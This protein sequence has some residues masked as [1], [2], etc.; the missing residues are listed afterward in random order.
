MVSNWDTYSRQGLDLASSAAS[1]GFSAAKFGTRL[2]FAVTRGIAST[3]VG[4]TTS[5]VDHTLFGG[6]TVTRPVVSGAVSTVLSLAEQITLAPI[7]L[8]EYITST[9]FLAAHSSIN[10]LSLIFPGSSEASFSLASFITLVKRE[11]SEP[12][13]SDRLPQ[14]QFGITQVARAIVAWVALQ[15]VTQEWQEKRWLKHL[16][17]INVNEPPKNHQ[18]SLRTRRGSRIRVTSDVIFSGTRSHIITADI[19]VAPSRAQTIFSSKHQMARPAKIPPVMAATPRQMSIAELKTT[20]R[21]LSKMVLAGYGGA[22]LLFFGVPLTS[23]AAGRLPSG[24]PQVKAEEA[25]LANAVIA[26]EAE[27]AG[28]GSEPS[29]APAQVEYSWWDVLLGRHDHEI[30]EKFAQA[31]NDKMKAD[32]KIGREHLMPRFW[33]LTD[34][35]RGQVVLVLRGTMSLNEIAVDLTC[36]SEEFEPATTEVDEE[37]ES[38]VPGRFL[39]PRVPLSRRSSNATLP[40][41]RY[42]VHSGMLRMARA[43]GEVGKPVQLAVHEALYKNPGYE[44]VLCGHSLG[45]GVAALLGLMWADPRTCLTVHSSGL[46]VGRRVSVYCFAPPALTDA[47]LSRLASHLIVSFVYSH[48]VV[49]RLS[50]GS[51]RDLKN[52]AMWLC[53]A[54]EGDRQDA[55]Y[56]AVTNRASQ[57]KAGNGSP[58]DPQWFIA[59]R[60]TLEAN[61]QMAHTFPPGRVLWALRESDLHPSHRSITASSA[62]SSTSQDKLRLFEVLDVEKVFSQIVFAKDMLGAHMPHKYDSVLHDLL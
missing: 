47:S 32:I 55:G 14:K 54:N 60:K 51:V 9:S 17:E 37:L 4:I 42:H 15:G 39:F 52:A 50:L 61:M 40:S 44:L 19:G 22:S 53:D 16:K 13:H 38:H 62:A 46:P 6:L 58:E 45:A 7:H 12:L 20:L 49:S 30:F 10:V 27:A 31:P 48:D 36:D 21:R 57:W 25:Q 24:A 11:W 59:V 3:A 8:S 43:M 35:S 33:V 23:A 29:E 28:D 5:V 1:F 41:G 2:G 56:T 26:S 34:H 18:D